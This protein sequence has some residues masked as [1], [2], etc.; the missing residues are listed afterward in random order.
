ML[1]GL[2]LLAAGTAQA[3]MRCGTHLVVEGDT[4]DELMARCGPP[5]SVD[6]RSVA[7]PP[8]VWRYGRPIYVPGGPIDT[9]VEIWTYNFG[10]SKFMQRVQVED[11]IVKSF[12]TLGYGY[13]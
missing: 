8:V 10:S 9:S 13:D 3:A 11:G 1:L 4:A 12:Q 5:V 2:T 6:R 7:R